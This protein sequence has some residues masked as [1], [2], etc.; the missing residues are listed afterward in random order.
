ML[1]LIAQTYEEQSDDGSSNYQQHNSGGFL[2]QALPIKS[3][4]RLFM[5]TY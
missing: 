2:N 1:T 4:E 3:L 5:A